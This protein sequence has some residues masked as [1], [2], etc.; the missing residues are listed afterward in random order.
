M[1]DKHR[2][3]LEKASSNKEL[4]GSGIGM[5]MSKMGMGE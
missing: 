4:L 1:T 5:L 2:A 3:E